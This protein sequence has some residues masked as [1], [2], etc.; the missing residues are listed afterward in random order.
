MKLPEKYDKNMQALLGPDYDKYIACLDEPAFKGIR[1]NTL[2]LGVE[3]FKKLSLFTLTPVPWAKNGFY[4]SDE[5]PATHPF[6]QAGLY[7]IQEPSAMISAADLPIEEGD[8]V[9]DLCAAPGGKSTELAAKLKGTGVLVSNDV[10]ASRTKALLKNLEVFGTK[11]AIIT[12]EPVHRLAER[13]PAYFDKILVDAPCS[14]EGMFRKNN[15][16]AAAWSD[17]SNESCSGIQ[18]EILKYA[19]RMLKPG[20]MLLYSTCT[21]S[22]DENEHSVEWLL[23][24][25]EDLYIED[26]HKY[27]GFDGGHPE[28][29]DTGNPELK[30]AVRIWPHK[31]KGEGHFACL[32]RKKGE[33]GQNYAGDYHVRR[34]KQPTEVTEFISRL[35]LKLDEKRIESAGD[36]LYYIPDCFPEITGLKIVRCG[37]YLG[38]KKKNRFEPSQALAMALRSDEFDNVADF[39]AA[40][41]RVARYLKGETIDTEADGLKDGYCLITV[42]GYPLGWGKNNK[43]LIKNKYLA[44]WRLGA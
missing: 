25:D 18:K 17:D 8:R 32:L 26:L 43:G 31:A 4:Y 44:G 1:V 28:W 39:D 35:G 6:Y 20:G 10:S 23:S 7:Y 30:K 12:C 37:L 9:L 3:E 38:E 36:K 14:G 21:F 11:N 24:Q 19:V 5:R 13:F 2:K 16:L 40:D 22:P 29:G 41:E 34:S 15:D 27:E 33:S 42:N